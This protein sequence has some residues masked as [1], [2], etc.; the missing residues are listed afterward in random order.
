MGTENLFIG[1]EPAFGISLGVA[2]NVVRNWKQIHHKKHWRFITGLR[3]AKGLILG[4]SAQLG[5]SVRLFTGHC[6]LKGTPFKI[7][8]DR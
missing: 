3:Q 2:K 1:P 6:H 7:G 5:W 8:I 4:P